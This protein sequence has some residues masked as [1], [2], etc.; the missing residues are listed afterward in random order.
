MLTD[1][2]I[3]SVNPSAQLSLLLD[4]ASLSGEAE[5]M[6][7]LQ[8][9]AVNRLLEYCN[10]PDAHARFAQCADKTSLPIPRVPLLEWR[11]D[12]HGPSVLHCDWSESSEQDWLLQ[13]CVLSLEQRLRSER[14]RLWGDAA[15][16]E[17]EQLVA[18]ILAAAMMEEVPPRN[19]GR[20]PEPCLL[21]T[22]RCQ[23]LEQQTQL[24]KFLTDKVLRIVAPEEAARILDLWLKL[25]GYYLL[26][27]DVRSDDYTWYQAASL[28][29]L[30]RADGEDALL[31][32]LRQRMALIRYGVDA[33]GGAYYAHGTGAALMQQEYYFTSVICMLTA[34]LDSLAV[35]MNRRLPNGGDKDYR[36]DLSPPHSH[37]V[38]SQ[39]SFC[40]RVKESNPEISTVWTKARPFLVLLYHV[41]RNPMAH[42]AMPA[43]FAHYFG[44]PSEGQ[45]VGTM[46]VPLMN[47]G[48]SLTELRAMCDE[49]PLP[50]EHYTNLGF[51]REDFRG[52]FG[53]VQQLEPYLFCREAWSR[54][55][56]LVN[57][58]LEA[59]RYADSL[60]SVAAGYGSPEERA[61]VFR[62]K[63][64]DGLELSSE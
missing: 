9:V 55:R 19:S 21:V 16:Q 30:P 2:Q 5:S 35:L 14:H 58:T 37:D 56:K 1:K 18:L 45:S 31:K 8:Q 62:Q 47:D 11:K 41:M 29:D 64:L 6:D 40:E 42:Q 13:P 50:Y 39:W 27:H 26:R 34:L 12:E 61:A 24:Q 44:S 52:M 32:S 3:L 51:S 7:A 59:L 20:V 33:L 48:I 22:T 60:I 4:T 43:H 15:S 23:L 53:D 28:S 36:V 49:A 54:V 57:G 25:R 10:V 46:G 17:V 63:A 38:T